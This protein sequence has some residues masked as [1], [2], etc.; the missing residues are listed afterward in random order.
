[1]KHFIKRMDP[2]VAQEN[3]GSSTE[4]SEQEDGSTAGATTSSTTNTQ[5]G[6]QSTQQNLTG[7]S[8]NA[9]QITPLGPTA[10][11]ATNPQHSVHQNVTQNIQQ[12]ITANTIQNQAQN[13][14]G[15]IQTTQTNQFINWNYQDDMILLTNSLVFGTNWRK[16]A[17]Y[18]PDKTILA[19]KRRFRYLITEYN[20]SGREIST[21]TVGG[22]MDQQILD[23]I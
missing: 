15:N 18:L 17:S 14:T 2:S 16:M 11:P 12:N 20:M 1:M 22:M 4:A 23:I 9:S 13:V 8:Q 21:N 6:N 10:N 19:I 3:I 5:Q 7:T